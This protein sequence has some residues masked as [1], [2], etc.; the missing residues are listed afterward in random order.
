VCSAA[1]VLEPFT[2]AME[3]MK[4][5]ELLHPPVAARSHR[6]ECPYVNLRGKYNN[7]RNLCLLTGGKHKPS[8]RAQLS[9]FITCQLISMTFFI[10]NLLN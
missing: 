8:V 5:E 1:P 2:V 3:R 7:Y 6:T 10:M 9:P 4:P